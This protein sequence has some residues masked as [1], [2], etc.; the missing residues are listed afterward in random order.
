VTLPG[1][2]LERLAS[3]AGAAELRDQIGSLR[4]LLENRTT[5][6]YLRPARRLYEILIAPLEPILREF[7]D[8]TLVFVP[9]GPLRTIPMAA[10][11][12]GE[13]FLIERHAIAITPGIELTDPRPL[14][15]SS[16][17]SLFAGISE[18]VAGF[19]ALPGV[20]VELSESQAIL[21]GDILLD[22]EFRVAKFDAEL[23]RQPFGL[24][25]IA[26]HGEFKEDARESFLLTHD[27]RLELNELGERVS[28][29]RYRE[30]P[31]ELL[32]LSACETAAGSERAALG[33]SGMAVRAGA[34]SVLGTLWLVN[35]SATSQL[36]T[37]F[38][39]ALHSGQVS[40]ATALRRAQQGLI[41]SSAH[42]HP[43]YWSAFILIGSWL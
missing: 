31:L 43:G 26:T 32:T 20:P 33:L 12:D 28:R 5:R 29:F 7:P 39:R 3:K 36:L 4:V 9:D 40:R 15:V 11:H 1:G 17:R 25:H 19:A 16:L 6:Q 24:I 2:R 34:R 18:P 13:H 42:R 37:T 23:D 30:A 41:A 38:Y 27:G 35:D 21:G 8:S 14:D 22:G 10:L